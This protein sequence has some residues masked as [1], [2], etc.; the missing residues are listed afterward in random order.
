MLMMKTKLVCLILLALHLSAFARDAP[1]GA[2]LTPVYEN[3]RW[4]YADQGGRVVIAARFDAA[5][6]FTNGLARVGV[7]DEELPEIEARPNIK[8]GYIDESGRVLVELRYAVLRDFSEGLAAAA[9]LDAKRPEIPRA[10]R[11]DRRN[12]RWGYVDRGGREVVPI[13]FLAAGDFAEG[14]AAVNPGGGAGEGEGSLCGP[15]ANY[16]YID[17]AGA[18]VIKPQ[19][20]NASEFQN[21]RARV[22]IGRTTYAGRCL[23]CGPRFVGK[24]GFVDRSGKFVADGPKDGGAVLEEDREN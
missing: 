3:G 24:Q 16:G 17:R 22:F 23:C 5:L 18:F 19:F 11:G 10:G 1:Q 6:P 20:L 15:P 21:G 14:L 8:W 4:G 9:V 2:R 13:Q 7:V 12:L